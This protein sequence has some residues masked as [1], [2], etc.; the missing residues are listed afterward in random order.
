MQEKEKT[1][2]CKADG[3]RCLWD[4]Y[5]FI[6]TSTRARF[7]SRITWRALADSELTRSPTRLPIFG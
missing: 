1:M 7:Q 3:Q 4:V 2:F 6:S 5:S